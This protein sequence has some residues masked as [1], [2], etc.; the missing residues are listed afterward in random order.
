M[1]MFEWNRS[2]DFWDLSQRRCVAI[3]AES[4]NL[5]H[6]DPSAG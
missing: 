2:P 3:S 4:V 1:Q 5:A 6:E